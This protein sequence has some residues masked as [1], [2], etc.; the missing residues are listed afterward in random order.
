[1]IVFPVNV[2]TKICMVAPLQISCS[3]E[4]RSMSNYTKYF[5]LNITTKGV[6]MQSYSLNFEPLQDGGRPRERGRWGVDSR[7][8]AGLSSRWSKIPFYQIHAQSLIRLIFSL[9]TEYSDQGPLIRTMN[10]IIIHVRT[11]VTHFRHPTDEQSRLLD[12]LSF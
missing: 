4:N 5:C 7:F 6:Q 3:R 9:C 10:N 8:N 11:Q 2:L 1:M 12:F